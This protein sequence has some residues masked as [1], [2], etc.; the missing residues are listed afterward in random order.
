[1]HK[2]IIASLAAA[3]FVFASSAAAMAD[4]AVTSLTFVVT[5]TIQPPQPDREFHPDY[6]VALTVDQLTAAWNAEI[7]RVFQPV[8][9]GGG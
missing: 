2:Q 9:A 8:L 3:G 6:S 4:D 1:V 5:T 7:D